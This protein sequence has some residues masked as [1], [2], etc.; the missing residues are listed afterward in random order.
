MNDWGPFSAEILESAFL[1]SNTAPVI[2][3]IESGFTVY[4]GDKS[5]VTLGLVSDLEKNK[6]SIVVW[7]VTEFASKWLNL[8]ST[9]DSNN[10]VEI[11]FDVNIPADT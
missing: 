11:S 5:T 9:T 10:L 7:Y 1:I 8:S 3:G 6:V 4:K 2:K